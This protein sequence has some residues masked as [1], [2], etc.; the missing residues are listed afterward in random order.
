MPEII[1]SGNADDI[2]LVELI[3]EFV[4][5]LGVDKESIRKVLECGD[6]EGLRRLAHQMKGAGESYGYP[7]LTE[8]ATVLEEAAKARDVEGC[9]TALDKFE[10]LC[11][12]TGL[13]RKV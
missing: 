9:T 1:S 7:M 8:A 10:I 2:D 4:A 5:G 11:Q 3:D 12:T 6:Y 13:G